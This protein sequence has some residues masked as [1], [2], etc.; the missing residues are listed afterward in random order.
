MLTKFV[1]ILIFHYMD[2][3]FLCYP[4]N[5]Y[6]NEYLTKL[7]EQNLSIAL[8]KIQKYILKK[9]LGYSITQQQISIIL[10]I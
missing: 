9:I 3:I 6:L 10:S 5:Q 7:K 8:D 1:K 4:F 2:D